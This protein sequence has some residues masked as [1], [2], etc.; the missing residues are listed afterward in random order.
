[1]SDAEAQP[2]QPARDES[3]SGLRR[4]MEHRMAS[5]QEAEER[6]QREQS[7]LQ[8]QAKVVS[9]SARRG[10][11]AASASWPSARP[12]L[13]SARA[14]PRRTR[15][16]MSAPPSAPTSTPG[17]RAWK[18][19]RPSSTGASRRSSSASAT[20]RRCDGL[21]T[22]AVDGLLLLTTRVAALEEAVATLEHQVEHMRGQRG[23][24]E[25]ER[26]WLVEQLRDRG[27]SVGGAGR[28][29]DAP[30][31]ARAELDDREHRAKKV[32]KVL[33]QK[34][35]PV[36]GVA[37]RPRAARRRDVREP[38]GAVRARRRRRGPGDRGR[39]RRDRTRGKLEQLEA[40][41]GGHG[42]VLD[43]LATGQASLKRPPRRREPVEHDR[44][45]R[46]EGRRDA[47]RHRP[48]GRRGRAA[49]RRARRPREGASA[50]EARLKRAR[51]PRPRGRPR[52]SRTSRSASGSCATSTPAG[53]APRAPR[54]ARA[55]TKQLRSAAPR[56]RRRIAQCDARVLELADKER[57]LT[58]INTRLA[59]F[60]VRQ[61]K[62]QNA[63]AEIAAERS[64]PT[65]SSA[66]PSVCRTGGAD[67]GRRRAAGMAGRSSGWPPTC[68]SAKRVR[69]SPRPTSS[70]AR[71]GSTVGRTRSTSASAT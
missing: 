40:R 47:R 51:R 7:A 48:E 63:E 54:R 34:E 35:L 37:R 20:R 53:R 25:L 23:Q 44:G 33:T 5:L 56:P 10:L 19:A 4:A 32:E 59:E 42:A 31:D 11:R 60:D 41:R 36:D 2:E 12:R 61:E 55:A 57:R 18:S 66:R 27:A 45:R 3:A 30:N 64:R 65:T 49:N 38:A 67:A 29:G 69:P 14:S 17:T 70:G 28:A 21:P 1:M 9:P 15:V 50:V 52:P 62:I 43:E 58:E 16:R 39:D 6:L 46:G 22:P 13:P 8:E 68:A 26:D 24:V 71:R